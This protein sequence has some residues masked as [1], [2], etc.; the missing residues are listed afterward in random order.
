VDEN[1]VENVE[2][3]EELKNEENIDEFSKYFSDDVNYEP[4][5][6]MTT[7]ERPR[8]ELF[9]FMKEIK[10]VFPNCH[11]WP[12]KNFTLKEICEYAP[13]RGYTDVMVWREDKRNVSELIMVHLP[14]GPTMHFRITSVVL[15]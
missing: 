11:Y 6:L 4:K 3:D 5:V 15:N 13:S 14:A 2:N 9:D 8:R 10:D 12:R 7:S 1:F